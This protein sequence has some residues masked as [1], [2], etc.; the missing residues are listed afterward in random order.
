MSRLGKYRFLGIF[1]LTVMVAGMAW[2]STVDASSSR[3][4]VTY[5]MI[6][7]GVGLGSSMPLFM[8]A[9]QNAV[10]YRVMGISTSTMQFLRSVGGTMGVAILFSIIQSQYHQGIEETVPA[11]VQEQPQLQGA[12]ADP[13]FLLNTEARERIEA[14]FAAFG[15]TGE[16]LFDQTMAGVRTSLADGISEAFFIA[17]FVLIAALGVSFFMKEEPL[18]KTHALPEDVP[19]PRLPDAERALPPLAGGA[20]GKR[21]ST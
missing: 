7:F 14:G 2:L 15:P 9:V 16:A 3:A 1:G 6:V 12:L 4:D 21:E 8:L 18:R 11:V 5:A 20:N 10:P 17:I 19:A 13:Q